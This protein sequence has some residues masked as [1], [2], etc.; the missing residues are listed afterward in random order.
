MIVLLCALVILTGWQLATRHNEK[1]RQL[2]F[3][4]WGLVYGPR[5]RISV[6]ES[7][8]AWERHME[9][10]ALQYERESRGDWAADK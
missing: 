10:D 1:R 4:P 8:R 7:D 9:L 6:E 3:D 5:N 2:D